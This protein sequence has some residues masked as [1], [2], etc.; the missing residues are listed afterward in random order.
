MVKITLT[1]TA[2]VYATATGGLPIDLTTVL[3]QAAPPSLDNLNPGDIVDVL[4]TTLS[5][6]GY[7]VGGFAL[8]T[9]TY[10]NKALA[11][12]QNTGGKVLATCPATIRLYG[13]HAGTGLA[14]VADGAI[15]DAVSL[16]LI[17]ARGGENL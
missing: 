3:Q 4:S 10:T 16:L 7:F 8:G 12:Q 2:T 13:T 14:E 15:T 17:I 1:A 9:P 5:T 11:S 6:N